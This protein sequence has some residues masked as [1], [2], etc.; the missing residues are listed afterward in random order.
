[1]V[2]TYYLSLLCPAFAT[3]TKAKSPDFVE[4]C[5]ANMGIDVSDGVDF[6]KLV[7]FD[8]NQKCEEAGDFIEVAVRLKNSE[9][10]MRTIEGIIQQKERLQ[11][12]VDKLKEAVHEYSANLGDSI[13]ETKGQQLSEQFREEVERQNSK[14]RK[15]EETN[16]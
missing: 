9:F 8:P 7:K 2:Q 6:F 10:S 5:S 1:M 12:Q 15:L 14:I 3:K 11:D 4:M 16:K 13:G